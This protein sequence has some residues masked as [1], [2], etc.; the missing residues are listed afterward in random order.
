[1]GA[2]LSTAGVAGVD[3][4]VQVSAV[5]PAKPSKAPIASVTAT[6]CSFCDIY[7]DTLPEASAQVSAARNAKHIA[8]PI[9]PP[10]PG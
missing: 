2:P 3:D 5:A 4:E 6:R 10:A 7:P 8:G 1:M 9:V